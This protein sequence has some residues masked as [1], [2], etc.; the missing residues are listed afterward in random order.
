[1]GRSWFDKRTTNGEASPQLLLKGMTPCVCP[2]H[3]L[4]AASKDER[5]LNKLRANGSIGR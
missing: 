5:P 2:E 3:A 4:P 1:M